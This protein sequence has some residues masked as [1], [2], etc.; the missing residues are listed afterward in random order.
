MS[1]Q[2]KMKCNNCNHNIAPVIVRTEKG[3][4]RVIC[5]NSKCGMKTGNYSNE[6]E[7]LSAWNRINMIQCT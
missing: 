5:P 2:K 7:A 1:V 4:V 6:T 3:R